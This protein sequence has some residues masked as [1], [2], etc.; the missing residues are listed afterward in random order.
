MHLNKDKNKVC[1]AADDIKY[2]DLNSG[3]REKKSLVDNY[4]SVECQLIKK[5]RRGWFLVD[6]KIKPW[7]CCD[8]LY[9]GWRTSGILALHPFGKSSYK[10]LKKGN[11]PSESYVKY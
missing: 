7:P 1:I 5:K 11:D 9:Q 4:I 10:E 6:V 8:K 3:Y 2:N